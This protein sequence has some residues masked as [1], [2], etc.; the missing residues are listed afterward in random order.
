[1]AGRIEDYALIGDLE[2]AALVGRDGSIDWLCLPRFDSGACFAALLGTEDNGRWIISPKAAG[3]RVT[4][5]YRPETLILETDFQTP[6]GSIRLIDFMPPRTVE[7]DLMRLVVGLKGSVTVRMELVIRFDY[8]SIVPWVRR[9]ETGIRAIA[10]PD[11]VDFYSRVPLKGEK[12]RTI[13]EFTV[14]EGDRIPFV[15]QWRPSHE[16]EGCVG[17]VASADDAERL[18]A[19][20]DSFWHTW[21][22]HCTYEG[23]YR[24]Q[25]LRSLITLK[26]LTYA[27]TGGVVAAP[28]TSLPEQLGG[29]RNWDYRY[30]WVRDATFT[31]YA[32]IMCGFSEEAIAWREWLL[33][34]VA[35][36]ASQINIMYG[37]GGERRLTELELPWLAGYENSK[38]VRTGNAAHQQLQLDIF[39]EIMDALHAARRQGVDCDDNS[40]RLEINLME[41]LEQIWRNPDEGIWEVRGPRRNFTHSKVMAWVAADRIVKAIEH[42]GLPGDVA[43]WR[44]MRDEIHADVC[45]HG[46]NESRRSFVQYYGGDETDASLLMLPLV[47]FIEADDP[48]MKGTIEHI[49][50]TLMVD[51]LVHRYQT[52]E[53]VDGLPAGEAAFLPCTF[54]LADNYWLLGRHDEARKVFERLLSL[55]NDVGLLAE[56]YSPQHQRL[57]GNFPQAFTHVALVNSALNLSQRDQQP[58][59]E[60]QRA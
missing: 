39:G 52:H 1:M 50:Q 25:V 30:C 14:N 37:L 18:L 24:E 20:G 36:S 15:L 19:D 47:G 5:R 2:T 49:E 45:Q 11:L 42:S 41:Y 33:R 9:T 23:P 58:A 27:P 8:G 34:A 31:L 6:E 4:R 12:L 53:S 22:D 57:L 46:Y 29:V 35:G 56:E 51:G 60:R 21:S 43:R 3:C 54:W 28:T 40:W 59:K 17:D 10:G 38:P 55:A 26:A 7:P 16:P 44:K 32:L 13:A 48:R